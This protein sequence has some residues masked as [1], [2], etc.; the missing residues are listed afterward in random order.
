MISF[1][2][3][4]DAM[5]VEVALPVPTPRTFTYRAP[6]GCAPG[7][8]VRVRFA[9]RRRI[10]W[11]V[12]AGDGTTPAERILDV[13]AVL[14]PT[15]SVSP[16]L[17]A[18]CQWIADYY[19][20]PLG[21]VLRA[22]LPVALSDERR[23]REPERV[24][25]VVEIIMELPS[26]QQRDTLFGRA[27]RQRE[28]YE[29]L[30]SAG[31][32]ADAVHLSEQLGYSPTVLR[33]LLDKELV[34]VVEER[35]ERDPFSSMEV[36]PSPAHILTDAQQVAIQAIT[37]E[38]AAANP[39][40]LLGVTGSGKTLV[41]MEA[42]RQ[43]VVEQGRGAIVLV[44]EIALTPQ[45]VARFRAH[46]G[47]TV[48]VLHSALSDGERFDAW[49]ALRDG[50][51]RIAIG[52]RSAIFA[53]VRDLGAI[54]VD[55]EHESSY[56]QSESPRYHARDAAVMRARFAGAVCVL[57]SATPS[58][59]SWNNV[60]A[61]KF[62]LV[63]LPQRIADRPLPPVRVIDLRAADGEK[64][65][66]TALSGPLVKAIHDRLDRNEQVILL[67]NRRGY[68]TF[69]QCRSCGAVWHCSAC[70]VSLTYHKARRR[71]V[72][73]YCFHEEAPPVTCDACA[74]AD[75]AFRGMGT[76]QVEREVLETFPAA[77]VARMDVDTT[78]AKWSH[79]E[80]LGRVE[81]GEIDI[82]L[83]T[84]MIAKG[85][86]FPGVTLVGVINA[87]VAMNLPDFRASERTFQLLTQVAGRA[88]RGER[89]GEV[90]VQSGLPGHYAVDRAR[91]HDYRGF[92]QREL[93]ERAGPGYP[94][95]QRMANVVI[96]GTEEQ[97]TQD[98][99]AALTEW[100][101]ARPEC[102]AGT[103]RVTGP[104]PCPIDRI[105]GRWRWHFFLRSSVPAPLGA[106]CHQIQFGF[107]LKPGKAALR[108]IIDRDPVTLL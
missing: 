9:G 19:V 86:D 108:L 21:L 54:I 87:D 52:A 39:L 92:A 14:E 25:R 67:L 55:E 31:G 106:V 10:G 30:E 102:V 24:R 89:G 85:L 56:K 72:C 51:R 2:S 43:I 103:V 107:R 76:E 81:R 63:E 17:L 46:F 35:D 62:A 1:A 105:R 91:E 59:E 60:A 84:Q 97:E 71:L 32:R 12:G 69:V 82:L 99:A 11:V 74:S 40:L 16:D 38:G 8:R 77:R 64:R 70:N 88:G 83:G 15:P 23:Q 93:D 75:L 58:L 73:H 27:R 28:C 90:M 3:L 33:G 41:Y 37:A 49:R 18:L 104:A 47:D 20:A 95:H 101:S 78:S 50:T 22:A 44:P 100:V 57:G 80:I 53:P 68:S 36:A 48:A 13:E 96:S 5:L 79:H 7:T 45:T 66:R 26:L 65:E 29:A 34:R 42:L 4:S 94:P 6:E 98:A 61:G